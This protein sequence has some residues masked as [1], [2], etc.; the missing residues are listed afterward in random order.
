[1]VDIVRELGKIKGGGTEGAVENPNHSQTV[2][3]LFWLFTTGFATASSLFRPRRFAPASGGVFLLI[4]WAFWLI[5]QQ[6]QPGRHAMLRILSP[7]SPW[8]LN[9]RQAQ[10]TL[11]ALTA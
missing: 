6:K 4:D 1:M 9:E 8:T 7:P 5:G 2:A 3:A 11:D 10:L